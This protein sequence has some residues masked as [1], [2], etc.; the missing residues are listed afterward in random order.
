MMIL[1]D[2]RA[3]SH[4]RACI[5]AKSQPQLGPGARMSISISR[6]LPGGHVTNSRFLFRRPAVTMP[7]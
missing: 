2:F 1:L 5:L 7:R 6:V 3:A 4:R